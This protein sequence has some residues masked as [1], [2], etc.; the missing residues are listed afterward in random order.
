[1]AIDQDVLVAVSRD[2]TGVL[3]LS[4]VDKVKYPD[5]A[6]DNITNFTIDASN[7]TWWGYFQCGMKGVWEECNVVKPKGLKLLLS[8]F[9][10]YLLQ[11][12]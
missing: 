4:N 9:I 2:E 12:S 7:P 5:Y 3:E 11:H 6:L 1:M 10:R 8:G